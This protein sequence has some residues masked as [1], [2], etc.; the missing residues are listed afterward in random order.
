M[1]STLASAAFAAILVV[2]LCM[3]VGIASAAALPQSTTPECTGNTAICPNNEDGVSSTYLQCDSWAQKYIS[4]NCPT[5]Q[6]C[7]ANPV[8]A[9][10][11]MCA[12]PGSGGVPSAGSCTGHE[13]K[14]A[15]PGKSADYFSCEPWSGQYVK[16]ACT[17]GLICYNNQ[18]NTGV[19]CL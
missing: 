15:D 8:S 18:N 1:H 7:Y 6:V 4:V 14:C 10:T 9:G 12:P 2:G 11:I 5:D 3:N 19:L 13:A 17:S 16:D